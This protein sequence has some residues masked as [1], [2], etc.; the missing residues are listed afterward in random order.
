MSGP[1]STAVAAE[2]VVVIGIF[3][4]A[5]IITNAGAISAALSGW[6]Q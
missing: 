1:V 5:A 6:V 2:L 4:F 3:M